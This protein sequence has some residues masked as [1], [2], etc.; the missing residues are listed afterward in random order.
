M[1]FVSTLCLTCSCIRGISKFLSQQIHDRITFAQPAVWSS[2]RAGY[3]RVLRLALGGI[4]QGRRYVRP[5]SSTQPQI[6]A[7]RR[8]P[9]RDVTSRDNDV[10]PSIAS[11]FARLRK[12][13]CAYGSSAQVRRVWSVCMSVTV[14]CVVIVVV[15]VTSSTRLTTV[16]SVRD[17]PESFV[18][19]N[20]TLRCASTPL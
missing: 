4:V 14:T 7:E 15:I 2:V 6:Q 5:T 12:L 16:T 18:E 20:S 11:G 3:L 9:R 8:R 10:T 17:H 13:S 19:Q 1:I